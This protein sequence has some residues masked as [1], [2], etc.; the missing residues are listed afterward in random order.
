MPLIIEGAD[1][2]GKTTAAKRLVDIANSRDLF[3]VHYAHMSRPPAQFDFFRDY[4]RWTHPYCVQDRFHLGALVWHDPADTIRDI[5]RLRL[6]E[7]RLALMGSFT[8]VFVASDAEWYRS[9]IS[10]NEKAEMFSAD[11]ILAGNERYRQLIHRPVYIVS[12]G[13]TRSPD[14]EVNKW[15]PC[16]DAVHYI[17]GDNAFPSDD[18]LESWVSIWFRRMELALQ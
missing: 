13:D 16:V 14:T 5:S 11:V 6:I 7:A 18:V 2:L 10:R 15:A 1:N 4:E 17:D 9:W 3:P 8:V 12:S